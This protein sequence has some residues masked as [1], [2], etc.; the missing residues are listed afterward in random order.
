[1]VNVI[2]LRDA[3]PDEAPALSALAQRS[4]AHWGYSE[5]FLEACRAELT[6][7]AAGLAGR[8]AVVAESAGRMLGFYTLDGD[9]PEG[10]LGNLWVDP[11]HIG[12]G[13][14]RRLWAHAVD[15][16]RATGFRT[17]RID[18]DPHAE[19]FYLAMGAQRIG[20]VPSGSVPGRELPLLSVAVS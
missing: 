13:V 14:G 5:E 17:L 8:R 12:T 19:G 2:E 10:E 1:L 7:T 11:A 3:R 9:P 18:A 4:K 6:F 15:T 16:A 20:A